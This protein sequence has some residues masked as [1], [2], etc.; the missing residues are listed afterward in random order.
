[1]L[2]AVLTESGSAYP[3]KSPCQTDPYFGL[4]HEKA[5]HLTLF[6]ELMGVER[7]CT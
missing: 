7:C 4:G 2:P 3:P 6:E 5:L 1:M